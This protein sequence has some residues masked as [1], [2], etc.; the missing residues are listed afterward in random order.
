MS[1]EGSYR[2]LLFSPRAGS[3]SYRGPRSIVAHFA[4]ARAALC[5]FALTGRDAP[6]PCA[7]E[8]VTPS[9]LPLVTEDKQPVLKEK[10]WLAQVGLPIVEP[11]HRH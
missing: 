4:E 7:A 10:G 2:T 5:R 6:P 11:G 9:S 1:M 8:D 3:T